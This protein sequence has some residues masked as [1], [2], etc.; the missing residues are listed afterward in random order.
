[1]NNA[2]KLKPNAALKC[3][4]IIKPKKAIAKHKAK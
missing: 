3:I 4:A 1:M 2:N